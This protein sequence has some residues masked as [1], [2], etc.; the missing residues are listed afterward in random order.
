MQTQ[1]IRGLLAVCA[2]T[3]ALGL[4]EGASAASPYAVDGVT[5]AKS[6]WLP[7]AYQ[8]SP[9]EQFSQHSWCRLSR[10]ER[11]GRGAF[12]ATTS[13]LRDEGRT[14]AYV[15]REI[16]PAFFT[17]D[18]M[19]TEIERLSARFGAPARE[20]RL[21]AREDAPAAV[22]VLWGKLQLEELPAKAVPSSESGGPEQSL[23]VDYL[24]D[25][26]QSRQLGLPI[27]RLAGGAGYLWSASDRNGRGHLRF[28]AA[29]AAVLA[30]AQGQL[31]GT[32]RASAA[33]PEPAE[34]AA[35]SRAGVAERGVAE[36][37]K[38]AAGPAVAAKEVTGS[39]RA[40]DLRA[41]LAP[42]QTVPLS[43]GAA[44]PELSSPRESSRVSV[45]QKTRLD[46][47]RARIVNAERMAAQERE[48]AQFAWARFEAERAA[49]ARARVKWTV[50][51]AF[52]ILS[53][54]LALL[55]MLRRREEE[56]AL[57]E[58]GTK[59]ARDDAPPSD[60]LRQCTSAQL[61]RARVRLRAI[62]GSNP[63]LAAQGQG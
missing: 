20:L 52:F 47:D 60:G 45:A 30:R 4:G 53:A 38:D 9:S 8:C 46:A 11:G 37:G 22:I 25:V 50:V 15:S 1:L 24:G 49:D 3:A 19:E 57:P 58:A 56:A 42:Q 31:P 32:E 36:A 34:S 23:L 63:S 55:Q 29:D 59:T 7:R 54:I 40:K 62:F 39:I 10:H 26:Q 35:K 48:K 6:L 13:V 16:A 28:L 41:F 2:S 27:F 43:G 44:N 5:L 33:R 14:V 21:P 18:D 12:T 51:A 17:T 61:R